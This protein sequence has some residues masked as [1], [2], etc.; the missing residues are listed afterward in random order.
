MMQCVEVKVRLKRKEEYQTIVK[1]AEISSARIEFL[2]AA[3]KT[4][5]ELRSIPV[6]NAASAAAP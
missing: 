3:A 1:A 2:H 6:M 4:T 5:S